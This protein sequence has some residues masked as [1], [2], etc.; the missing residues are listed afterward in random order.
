MTI[1]G[2]NRITLTGHLGAGLIRVQVDIGIGDVV[3]PQPEEMD[4]P[5]ILDFPHPQLKAYPPEV[6][7]AEK[8]QAMVRL[9]AENTRMKDF[10]DIFALSE[11]HDFRGDRLTSAVQATFGR[12]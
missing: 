3:E 7:V 5:V 4:Y 8:L 1:T 6:V 9:G 12:R 10:F 2:G 11:T